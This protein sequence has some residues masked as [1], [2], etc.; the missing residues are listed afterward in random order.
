[1]GWLI[2]VSGIDGSGKT[3]LINKFKKEL[4][5]SGKS[6]KLAQLRLGFTP[7]MQWIKKIL[8]VNESYL[9]THG[10]S[11]SENSSKKK[12]GRK[13]IILLGYRYLSLLDLI[14]YL[15][16]ISIQCSFGKRIIIDRYLWDNQIIYENKYGQPG[17]LARFLLSIARIIAREP[18]VAFLLNIPPD[19]SYR[20]VLERN[21]GIEE[22]GFKILERRARM[23]DSLEESGLVMIDAMNPPERVFSLVYQEIVDRIGFS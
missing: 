8:R 17:R 18:D 4:D 21:D 6:V 14:F 13:K 23:Y 5:H 22:E 15:S 10:S 19:E 2:S 3:T 11:S 1:M 9:S 12:T 7:I 16:Q 20:R